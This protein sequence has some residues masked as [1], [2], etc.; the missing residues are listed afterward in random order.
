[1]ERPKEAPGRQ[2]VVSKELQ[3]KIL[4]P[5]DGSPL[6]EQA[7]VFA[8]SLA[9]LLG[10]EVVIFRALLPPRADLVVAPDLADKDSME[11]AYDEAEKEAAQLCA[12]WGEGVKCSPEVVA[13][14]TA[15]EPLANL[16][17]ELQDLI[18]AQIL[19]RVAK[20]DIGL[21]VLG[22]HGAS[23][24]TRRARGGV[25]VRVIHRAS[26]PVLMVPLLPSPDVIRHG[27]AGVGDDD[28]RRQF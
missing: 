12:A 25:A 24:E 13:V 15:R 10:T 19:G 5:W 20:P 28:E 3:G 7:L 14:D 23:A 16:R 27:P 26:K 18:A 9:R 22:G 2:L 6:A 4:F 1:M 17:E 11:S 21:V 8:I